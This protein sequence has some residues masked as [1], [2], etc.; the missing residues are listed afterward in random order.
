MQIATRLPLCEPLAR[1]CL[2][3]RGSVASLKICESAGLLVT[4]PSRE[5]HTHKYAQNQDSYYVG[6]GSLPQLKRVQ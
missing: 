2:R 3:S 6:N 4:L 1:I 5:M